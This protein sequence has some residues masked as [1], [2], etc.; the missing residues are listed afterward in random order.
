MNKLE[1]LARGVMRRMEAMAENKVIPMTFFLL[2]DDDQVL[3]LE[4]PDDKDIAAKGLGLLCALHKPVGY[5]VAAEAWVSRVKQREDLAT[6]PSPSEDPNRM[7]ALMVT[8]EGADGFMFQGSHYL[9]RDQE[10]NFVRLLGDT[11]WHRDAE[12]S[13]RFHGKLNELQHHIPP[14]VAKKMR[15]LFDKVSVPMHLEEFT[16]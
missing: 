11:H 13:G 4:A 3:L 9:E 6:A 2:M 8:A 12:L 1:Q 15:E 7:E 10:E 5:V 14:E 16:C